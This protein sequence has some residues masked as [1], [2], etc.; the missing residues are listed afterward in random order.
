MERS[1]AIMPNR[2]DEPMPRK[3]TANPDAHD[4]SVV[5]KG[6]PVVDAI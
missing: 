1:T 5:V 4:A 6:R 2:E 3:K